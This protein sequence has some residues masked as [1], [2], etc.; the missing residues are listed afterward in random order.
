MP[1]KVNGHWI[2]WAECWNGD[3]VVFEKRVATA[4]ADEE[5]IY[6]SP[7]QFKNRGRRYEDV[8]PT[9]WLWADLDEVDPGTCI[10][11]G[12]T[13]TLC[14]Q[15]SPGRFQ[16]LWELDH[17]CSPAG[18]E[19]LNRMVTYALGADKS[20][21]DLTQVLRLPG[22][23]NFKYDG[24]PNVELVLVTDE[25]YNPRK[26]AR[27]LKDVVP[28]RSDTVSPEVAQSRKGTMT[29]EI[30]V[31]LG[32]PEDRVVVGERSNNRWRLECL[33]LEAG[34]GQQ[35]VFEMVRETAWNA[36]WK[37]VNT[38]DAQL[39]REIRKAA[40]HIATRHAGSDRPASAPRQGVSDGAERA[41]DGAGIKPELVRRTTVERFPLEEK[42]SPSPFVGYGDFLSTNLEAPRWLVDELWTAKSHGLVGGEPKSMKSVL[43]LALAMSV[44][45]GKPWLMDKRF[46][47]RVV[48]PVLMVQEENDP[49]VMQDRTRKIARAYGLIKDRDVE[50]QR[51]DT[52]SVAERITRL[53]FPR[54]VPV[55]FLNNY[56]FDLTNEDHRDLL[57]EEV[58]TVQP[59]LII[60]DPLYLMVGD[61]DVEKLA[62]MAPFFKW[63]IAL[64]YKYGCAPMVLHH[65]RKARMGENT[66]PGQRVLGTAGFH[67]WVEAAAY[68]ERLEEDSGGAAL[69]KNEVRVRLEREFRNVGPRK[70]LDIRIK[71]GDPGDLHFEAQI[72]RYDLEGQLVA[73]VTAQPGISA[74]AAAEELGVDKRTVMARV[75]GSAT[76]RI[77]ARGG[78]RGRGYSWQLYL[79]EEET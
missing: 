10:N 60:L 45:S 48:G 59:V 53:A 63:L 18:I 30:K 43:S 4:L 37:E 72:E 47:P 20:G 56:G 41:E 76:G 5:D 64:R 17:P 78:K 75:R 3:Q 54:E 61:A 40:S 66:R 58:R 7:A 35:E 27:R 31:L 65:F 24:G 49:W 70:P 33:M 29:R 69:G 46:M 13:P 50:S 9:Y 15:S 39:K 52:G 44:A 16:A 19:K 14:W 23:R 32:T 51:A 71:M 6:F 36:A 21:W 26:L 8:L 79:R 28:T 74:S 42:A 55:R 73:L 62:H 2:P 1:S 77:E 11:A 25:I 12:L 38:G 57:E 22:T 34:W 68:A 67:G